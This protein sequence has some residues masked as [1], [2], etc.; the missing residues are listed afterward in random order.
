MHLM[1]RVIESDTNITEKIQLKHVHYVLV[2]KSSRVLDE[3]RYETA[4]RPKIFLRNFKLTALSE[5][6]TMP[7]ASY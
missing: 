3:Y 7:F 1:N 4:E 5:S 2:D 6:S